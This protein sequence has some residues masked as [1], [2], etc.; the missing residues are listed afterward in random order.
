[1]TLVNDKFMS[2]DIDLALSER[3]FHSISG[4][5][6]EIERAEKIRIDLF[7]NFQ[8]VEYALPYDYKKHSVKMFSFN[9]LDVYRIGNVDLLSR[10]RTCLPEFILRVLDR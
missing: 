1:M 2:K 4:V 3:D 9:N 8:L 10:T 6:A 7:R 5:I